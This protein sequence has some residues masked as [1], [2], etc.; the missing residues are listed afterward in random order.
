M[1]VVV[2]RKV[3]YSGSYDATEIEG[4]ALF[5]SEDFFVKNAFPPQHLS[6]RC[7]LRNPSCPYLIL[8]E[9]QTAVL[10]TIFEALRAEI[11]AGNRSKSE[12]IGLKILELLIMCDRYFI[13]A[14]NFNDLD[15]PNDLFERLNTGGVLLHD[16]EIR[17]C[18]FRGKLRDQLKELS[19]N[20]DYR[21]AVLV[22]AGEQSE[23][24]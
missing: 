8:S 15:R 3:V 4:Y 7:L 24:N 16:Q 21:K 6:E 2:P 20:E 9:E 12:M 11:K 18:V 14:E 1:L 17:N 19:K 23:A 10:S 13:E 5:F 22:K